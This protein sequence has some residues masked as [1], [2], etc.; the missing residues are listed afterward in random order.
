MAYHLQQAFLE[1]LQVYSLLL[2]S[3]FWLQQLT[4]RVV[5]VLDYC[6]TDV[7]HLD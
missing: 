4:Y 6:P 1:T 2:R 5:G 3:Q 7:S